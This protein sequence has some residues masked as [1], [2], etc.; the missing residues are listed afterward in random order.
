M[1]KKI[2]S[3]LVL[4]SLF[5]FIFNNSFAENE[6]YENDYV[7]AAN[8]LAEKGIINNH[9]MD[10]ENYNLD[11][12]VLRQEIAAVSRWIAWLDKKTIC[13]WIFNDVSS[14]NPNNWACYS[15]EALADVHLIAKNENF[16]PEANISKAEAIGMIVKSAW[17]DYNY[18]STS[19]KIWQEQVVDYAYN[20]WIIDSKF[21]DYNASATRWWIFYVASIIIQKINETFTWVSF[22][23]SNN[24]FAFDLYNKYK[25]KYSN[26]NIFFS[27]YSIESALTMTYEWA[28]WSTAD[29]MR[30]VL[31]LSDNYNELR[32]SFNEIY[33]EINDE[34]NEYKLNTANALWLEDTYELRSDY[35]SNIENYYWWKATNLDFVNDTEN[36]RITINNWVEA[37]TNN[38]IKDL[39]S[40]LSPDTRLVL[41][42]AIYFKADWESEFEANDTYENT[43]TLKSW[44]WV[45][46]DFMHQT[47][48]FNYWETD[49]LKVIEMNYK[50]DD[51]SMLIL[52]P[53]ENDLSTIDNYLSVE[54][55]EELKNNMSD[56]K[57]KLTLPKFTFETKYFMSKDMQDLWMKKA[58]GNADFSKMTDTNNLLISQII[59]QTFVEV[60]EKWTEAAAATAVIMEITAILPDEEESKIFKADHPFVFIIQQKGSWNILFMWKVEEPEFK[61]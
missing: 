17:Y 59:H 38:K 15:V 11:D 43:F 13:D 18:D 3:L 60:N 6:L 24:L 61:E 21:S 32:T 37:Q 36:S 40:Y 48:T 14:T 35:L 49:D 28:N 8:S 46:K 44:L 22:V 10:P 55:L 53:K 50:W 19:D 52:L 25:D 51:L 42:N 29:E 58:F 12:Y 54:K 30:H 27:P 41:T 4:L 33:N 26:E 47:S 2:I 45:T 57:V 56:E 9:E 20:N 16:R 23:D 5:S 34:T 31:H 39:I 1:N 7:I